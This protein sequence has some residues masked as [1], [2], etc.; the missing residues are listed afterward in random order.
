MCVCITGAATTPGPTPEMLNGPFSGELG[1]DELMKRRVFLRAGWSQT[2]LG[3][4]PCLVLGRLCGS[5]GLYG[6]VRVLQQGES[7]L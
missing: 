6:A 7:S 5:A 4:P 3:P 1:V 2:S